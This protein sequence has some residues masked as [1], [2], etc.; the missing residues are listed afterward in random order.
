MSYGSFFGRFAPA[1]SL[2]FALALPAA[3][4]VGDKAGVTASV[5]GQVQQVSYS[6][7]QAIGRNRPD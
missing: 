7:P 5:R 2:A 1:L 3:A 4:A 6:T